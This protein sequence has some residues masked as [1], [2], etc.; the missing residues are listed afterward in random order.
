MTT[1]GLSDYAD[2]NI[3]RAQGG[4]PIAPV[5]YPLSWDQRHTFKADVDLTL[6]LD[7]RANVIVVANSARPYTYFPTRDGFT[8]TDTS[9]TLVPNNSRMRPVATVDLKAT[10][11]FMVREEGR[12]VITAFLDIRNLL[13]TSNVRWMDSNGRIGGEL[14]D[15]SAYY[16]PRRVVFGIRAEF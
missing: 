16:D 8:P 14:G 15:P 6:P 13:N 9:M 1:E 11:T 4:F 2:Q 5:A 7:I 3:N 12:M 10:R